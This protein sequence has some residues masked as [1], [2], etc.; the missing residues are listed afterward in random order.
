MALTETLLPAA[1]NSP[2]R[3]DD[4]RTHRCADLRSSINIVGLAVV[5][6][7]GFI[8][9][10]TRPRVEDWASPE[11]FSNF[12]A[13]LDGGGVCVMGRKTHQA[14]PNYSGRPRIVLTRDRALV[15]LQDE[16]NVTY[17]NAAEVGVR[18]LLREAVMRNADSATVFVLGGAQ[19]YSLFQNEKGLGY[20]SF[21]LTVEPV[22]FGAGL[23]LISG[24]AADRHFADI[25][26][27]FALGNLRET[28]SV[29]LNASGTRLHRF[30]LTPD[31]A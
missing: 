30:S 3:G 27:S 8:A 18:G 23:P 9:T 28:G 22:T 15:A 14:H 31:A 26:G 2:T 16:P 11:D 29:M 7:D 17:L 19:I 10:E 4:I 25:S 21:L 24:R 12:R 13:T 6:R 20:D 1:S 5:S